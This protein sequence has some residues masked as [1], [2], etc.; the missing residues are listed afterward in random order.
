MIGNFPGAR[1]RGG[2]NSKK[3]I[4]LFK[5]Y[6]IYMFLLIKHYSLICLK[7]RIVCAKYTNE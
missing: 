4:S 5:T 1:V 2:L 6:I 3:N 7:V